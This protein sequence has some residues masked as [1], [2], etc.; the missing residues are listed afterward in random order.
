MGPGSGGAPGATPKTRPPCKDASGTG[1]RL[2]GRSPGPLDCSSDDTSQ[3]SDG[4]RASLLL[5][6]NV[7]GFRR[8]ISNQNCKRGCNIKKYVFL[9]SW[10]QPPSAS[11]ARAPC[12]W[13][14]GGRLSPA[15]LP[16]ALPWHPRCHLSQTLRNR[17]FRQRWDTNKARETRAVWPRGFRMDCGAAP[18]SR[19]LLSLGTGSRPRPTARVGV[20]VASVTTA[21]AASVAMNTLA[22]RPVGE[23]VCEPRCRSIPVLWFQPPKPAPSPV[24]QIA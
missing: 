9:G 12:R 8:E 19:M 21:P 20:R 7:N 1:T 17:L 5:L 16:P 3:L 6:S 18:C 4:P 24:T 23:R 14:R 22:K 11:C 10:L 13:G 2:R 15:P